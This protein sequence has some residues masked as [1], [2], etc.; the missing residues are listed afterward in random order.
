MEENRIQAENVKIAKQ[1][2]VNAVA[3]IKRKV[4]QNWNRPGAVSE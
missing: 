4:T 3:L 1:A 2:A